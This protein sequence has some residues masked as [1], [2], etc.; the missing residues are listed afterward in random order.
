MIVG[1]T[2]TDGV[3][4]AGVLDMGFHYPPAATAFF[5]NDAS[6]TNPTGYAA[7]A[8]VLGQVWVATVDNTTTGNFVAGVLGY[9]QPAEL[10]LPRAD[11]YLLIDPR[12]PGG[13]LLGLSPAYGYGVVTF[14]VPIPDDVSLTG[15]TASTQGIGFGGGGGTSFHN[16]YDLFV[17]N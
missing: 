2:R 12:S 10:Y 14:F 13:E 9:S 17:G 8:P 15:F 11:D 6:A 5:R 16:A 7:N 4:D 3:Q 1:T